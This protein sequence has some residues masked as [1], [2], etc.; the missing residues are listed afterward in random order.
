MEVDTMRAL[1]IGVGLGLLMVSNHAALGACVGACS[2][3]DT[4]A[5]NDLIRGVNIA[6]GNAP[7][8]QCGSFDSNNDGKVSISE[9]INA[10]GNA[11]YG[12]GF[13]FPTPTRTPT[14]GAATA[15]TTPSATATP[16]RATETP[17][18]G[19]IPPGIDSRMLGT[20][21]GVARNS[22]GV[23]K[24]VRLTVE[25][26]NNQVKVS[27]LNGNLFTASGA[28]FLIMD[29]VVPTTLNYNA[30]NPP[31]YIEVFQL[32]RTPPGSLAGQYSTTNFSFPPTGTSFAMDLLPER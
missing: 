3:S 22:D 23:S 32:S 26:A 28:K 6:L 29:P 13:V 5:V 24:N 9:L 12:C 31:H 7:V 30:A 17:T 14:R 20:W 18:A 2:S 27:D 1:V 10:V 21:S 4:V 19:I 16:P 11:L 15:T 25:V 8:S